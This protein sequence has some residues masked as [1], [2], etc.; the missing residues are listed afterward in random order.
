MQDNSYKILIFFRNKTSLNH[1]SAFLESNCNSQD[2]GPDLDNT[3]ISHYFNPPDF[4]PVFRLAFEAAFNKFNA[5]IPSH[6]TRSLFW[7]AQ[8]FD[9]KYIYLVHWKEKIYINIVL[10]EN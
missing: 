4:Y 3:I 5:H 6:P 8:I 2:F 10:L 9:P 1:L 7:A